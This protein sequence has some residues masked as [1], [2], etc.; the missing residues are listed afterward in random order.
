MGWAFQRL[1]QKSDPSQNGSW[2]TRRFYISFESESPPVHPSVGLEGETDPGDQRSR[3]KKV[4]AAK[5]RQEVVERV[6]VG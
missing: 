6:D 5:C 4:R 1:R 3:L 2:A